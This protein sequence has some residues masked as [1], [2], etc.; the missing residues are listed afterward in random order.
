M[1]RSLAI[2]NLQPTS[3]FL[4]VIFHERMKK[5]ECL[6][7]NSSF[8]NAIY[9]P[10]YAGL[11]VGRYLNLGLQHNSLGSDLVKWLEQ[12]PEWISMRGSR[13]LFFVSGRIAWDFRRKSTDCDSDWGSKA[14][15]LAWIYE[16]DSVVNWNNLTEQWICKYHIPHISILQVTMR[17]SSGKTECRAITGAP[18]LLSQVPRDLV[19]MVLHESVKEPSQPKN[20]SY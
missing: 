15:D 10:F 7:N 11:G 20:L 6:T 4:E 19:R 1:R 2:I 3:S 16:P 18:C 13:D 9:V 17:Y 5:Y 14:Y 8:A 12:Q